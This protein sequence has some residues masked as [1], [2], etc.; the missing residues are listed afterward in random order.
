MHKRGIVCI[1]LIAVI[2]GLLAVTGC[3]SQNSL[4]KQQR[5]VLD[6]LLSCT[7][8]N[9][10]ITT[11]ELR[12]DAAQKY[13]AVEKMFKVVTEEAERYVFVVSPVGYR[14]PI[15]MMVAIDAEKNDVMGI[16]VM[17]HD[18]TPGYAEWLTEAWF[19]DRFKG[20]SVD[21]YLKRAILEAEESNEI[22]QITGASVTTQAVLNGVNSAMGIYRETVLGEK[23]DPVPLKVEG[24]IT[25]S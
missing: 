1:V 16:K 21:N 22:I 18:E 2:F 5:T 13:P 17:Q 10:Q 3:S 4:T 12:N 14:A 8:T 19:I 7:L 20:K 11:V 25:E 23:A 9:E 15:N 6:E 24:Y